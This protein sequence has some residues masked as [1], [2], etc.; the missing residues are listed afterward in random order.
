MTLISVV[1]PVYHNAASLRDVVE[2]FQK[3]ADQEP[4]D[5]EFI[6]VDDG[7][8]DES[9]Q[10]MT[11]LTEHDSRVRAIKLVRNFGSNAASSAGIA[12]AKGD[13]R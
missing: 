6:F 3:V 12:Y 7:S 2:R 9:F 8:R 10:V 13:A 4:E 5:F 11:E 1:V